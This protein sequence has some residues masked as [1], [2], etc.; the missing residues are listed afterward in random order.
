[1]CHNFIYSAYAEFKKNLIDVYRNTSI[2]ES[3]QWPP[4]KS[5][6]YINLALI[7]PEFIPR[8]DSYSRATIRGSVDDVYKKKEPIDFKYVFPDKLTSQ[9]H[10]VSLIQGRPGCGKSTLM[11]KVSRDWADGEILK[12]TELFVLVYLRQFVGR[13]DLT[14][15]DLFGAYCSNPA[16]LDAVLDRVTK[17]GGKGV[18]FAFDGLDEYSSK[19]K[20]DNIIMKLIHG[21]ELPLA[22]VYMTSRPAT[23][24]RF[25]NKTILT[26]S[27]EIIGFLEEEIEKYVH[28]YYKDEDGGKTKAVKLMNYIKDHPNI[29]RM[30]YLPLHIAMVVHLYDLDHDKGSLLP[31]TETELYHKFTLI[32]L[33][34]S[35]EK[36]MGEDCDQEDISL[37]EF[38]DLSI[39]WDAIFR[40]VC[41]LAF[42]A[43]VEQKQMFTGREIKKI[44]GLPEIPK[45]RDFDSV[46]LLTVDRT[47]VQ[48]SGN[49]ATTFSFFH[50]T[51]Q[52]FLAAVHIVD[53][54]SES[55][56]LTTIKDLAAKVHMWMVW[57]F[58]CGMHSRNSGESLSTNEV[59]K[60]AF[61][62]I[63]TDNTSSHLACLN[64]VHCAFESQ[65]QASCSDLLA[66]D[67][68]KGVINV[69]DIALNPSDC[70]ALGYVL[71]KAHEE[72][73][74]ID[75]S[76]CHLGPDGIAAFVK[77]LESSDRDLAQVE[78]LRYFQ[79]L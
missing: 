38:S 34:R 47:I 24:Q 72:I 35:S 26:Q 49:P 51:H 53:H 2:I 59:F 33:Y 56:Q 25:R 7:T 27:I 19:L 76:Y 74:E 32:T 17:E 1:M 18:C 70:S 14:L 3:T 23:S 43:T 15:K 30:C 9:K 10:F 12:D 62:L 52:E 42:S 4:V 77:Q 39:K 66:H 48:K 46:G 54:M 28:S 44:V 20:H 50:L 31:K 58:F 45:R 67:H 61:Q 57:K 8:S 64:M 79:Q 37:E 22:A 21:Q 78:V 11:I 13:E 68:I 6:F 73:K 63:I 41:K 36:E 29:Q 65:N 16:T 60:K 5:H 71:A 40:Q 55:E 69:V 75:F